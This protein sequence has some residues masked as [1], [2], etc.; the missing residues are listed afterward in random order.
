MEN[1]LNK[2]T[3][4][5]ENNKIEY[6]KAEEVYKYEPESFL[7]CSKTPRKMIEKKNLQPNDYIYKKKNNT[8]N[9]WE[10]TDPTYKQAKLF[11]TVEWAHQN[12]VKLNG[13][14]TAEN[15]KIAVSKAPPIL[16]LNDNEKF[17]DVEGTKLD[18][19][20]RGTRNIED[21][22]FNVKDI[23]DKFKL[24]DV[25]STVV[26]KTSTFEKDVHY[27][28][29]IIHNEK[30]SGQVKRNGKHLFLTFSGLI[31]L[32]YTSKSKNADHFKK[33]GNHKLFVNKMG[34]L[35][36]KIKLTASQLGI[37]AA[38]MREILRVDAKAL[39]CIYL[40]TLGYV[41]DLRKSMNIDPKYDDE[42]LVSKYGVTEDL[43][44]C[45]N[46]H[47]AIFSGIEGCNLTVKYHSYIDP[48]CMSAAETDVREYVS[49]H[50]INLEYGK[51]E[52]LC[53][54][55]KNQLKTILK[56]YQVIGK[57]YMGHVSELVTKIKKLEMDIEQKNHEIE[58]E[59]KN[60]ELAIQKMAAE[61]L[62]LKSKNN[63]EP[64]QVIPEIP[65]IPQKPQ[66]T[67]FKP[68]NKSVTATESTESTES[69]ETI[70]TIT[71]TITKPKTIK[72]TVKK[73]C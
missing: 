23:G 60:H 11:V 56:Q 29:F 30:N 61:I 48:Q 73:T 19:E 17:V 54:I 70:T 50:N 57:S 40:L 8:T 6:Y 66:K 49:S 51:H 26:H 31:S 59:R 46:D 25:T 44:K 63:Q 14:K 72:K 53:I 67:Q 58:I 55:P 22:Y 13:N 10:D 47:T 1:P 9:K 38:T 27:K 16:V 2:Y 41:K 4:D 24:G 32:L 28:I 52:E 15:L 64:I 65:E 34:T 21:M 71:T 43:Q 39:P 37:D 33:W 20:V 68:K 18:I 42:D 7:G 5:A 3:F 35:E 45:I 36:D 12:V 62:M 69:T